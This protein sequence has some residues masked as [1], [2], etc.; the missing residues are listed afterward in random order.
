MEILHKKGVLLFRGEFI[1]DN[2]DEIK[3][4]LLKLI[5]KIKTKKVKLDFID[6]SEIDSAGLQIVLS[7]C[8]TLKEKNIDFVTEKINDDIRH[9][10]KISGLGKYLNL[11]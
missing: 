10:L 4:I 9:I 6:V 8:K 2:V 3:K 11:I 1:L 5:P 7:F